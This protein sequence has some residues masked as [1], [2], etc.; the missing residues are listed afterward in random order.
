MRWLAD[1]LSGPSPLI[2]SPSP[3]NVLVETT[4]HKGHET[5]HNAPIP[6]TTRYRTV[7]YRNL[8]L[9]YRTAILVHSHNIASIV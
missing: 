3:E 2:G 8:N 7:K 1:I 5:L 6:L 4:L 9:P